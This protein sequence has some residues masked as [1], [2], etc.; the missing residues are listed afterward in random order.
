MAATTTSGRARLH[1][2]ASLH[3]CAVHAWEKRRE[4]TAHDMMRRDVRSFCAVV[5]MRGSCVRLCR[6][7]GP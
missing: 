1:P 6:V 7:Y 4:C 5:P 2:S 3:E